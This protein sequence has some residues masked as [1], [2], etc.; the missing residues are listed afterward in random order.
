M[1][2]IIKSAVIACIRYPPVLA[3]YGFIRTVLL[4]VRMRRERIKAIVPAKKYLITLVRLPDSVAAAEKCRAS[5]K[6]YGEDDNIEIFPAISQ[7]QSEA[8]FIKHGIRWHL[9][10]ST[11][12]N[13]AA[14]G[15]FASHM[16]LW[17]KCIEL[18]QPIIIMEHD[19]VFESR[20][21]ALAF[22]HI[23]RLSSLS[24]S[25]S[26]VLNKKYPLRNNT[27]YYYPCSHLI[28]AGAYAIT[29]QGA[30]LLIEKAHTVDYVSPA[31]WH[32]EKNTVDIIMYNPPPLRQINYFSSLTTEQ[33]GKDLESPATVW[34]RY[35]HEPGDDGRPPA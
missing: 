12:Y 21:P 4:Q 33:R 13:R 15:C 1:N 5:A 34:S 28:G 29:P 32:I 20:I 25:C 10:S 6:L 2:N 27:E 23:I 19:V 18:D 8:F 16:S 31:D 22:K 30:R 9:S 35:R 7:Y 3:L 24:F 26:P 11:L 14:M 17:I